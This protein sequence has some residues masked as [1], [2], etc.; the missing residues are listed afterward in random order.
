MNSVYLALAMP[1]L[2]GTSAAIFGYVELRRLR[3][4]KAA[5][6]QTVRPFD[7]YLTSDGRQFLTGRITLKIGDLQESFAE[8]QRIVERAN[9]S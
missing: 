9:K 6:K 2:L 4:R 7:K 5:Q 1:L 3:A 8:A